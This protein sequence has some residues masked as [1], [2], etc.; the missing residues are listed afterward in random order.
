MQRCRIIRSVTTGTRYTSVQLAV[1]RSGV[2]YIAGY[3]YCL[4]CLSRLWCVATMFTKYCGSR[5]LE[6]L[7]SLCTKLILNRD[8]LVKYLGF[9]MPELEIIYP[10]C[11]KGCRKIRDAE[12]LE[13]I[14]AT[15]TYVGNACTN[16]SHTE[17]AVW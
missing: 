13:D 2:Y 3:R 15:N 1:N 7:S 5:A 14:H 16:T 17:L 9:P 8:Q 11:A 12:F 6:K 4:V 10:I